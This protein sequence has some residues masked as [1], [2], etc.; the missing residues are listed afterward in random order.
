MSTNIPSSCRQIFLLRQMN[1]E[2]ALINSSV[3]ECLQHPVSQSAANLRLFVKNTLPNWLFEIYSSNI[4]CMKKMIIIVFQTIVW[5]QLVNYSTKILWMLEI[6]SLADNRELLPKIIWIITAI[7]EN[8]QRSN[9]NN[10]DPFL[11]VKE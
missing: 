5:Y 9:V 11:T 4:D 7:K 8:Y 10:Q 6:R 1:W 2:L 3:R